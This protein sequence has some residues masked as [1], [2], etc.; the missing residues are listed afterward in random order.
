MKKNSKYKKFIKISLIVATLVGIGVLTKA[1]KPNTFQT[2][3][4]SKEP[5]IYANTCDEQIGTVIQQAIDSAK[6]SIFLR[7]YRVSAPNIISSLA[8]QIKDGRQVTIHYQTFKDIDSLKGPSVLLVQHP[9]KE[10]KLM[11]QKALAIDNQYAWLGTAN[12]TEASF[13]QDSNVIIGCKS[14]HLCKCIVQDTSGS[15][16]INGQ[17][18][19]YYT[20]PKDKALVLKTV[21]NCIQSAKKTIQ[22]AMFAL[23][24]SPII[25][26]LQQAQQRGVK[27]EVIIDKEFKNLCLKHLRSINSTFPVYCK[28]TP[29]KLH[30]KMCIID[31]ET[32]LIG[33]VN[34]SQNG[35]CLNSESL[36][37]LE[38]LTPK[39]KNKL[40]Q[41]WTSILVQSEQIHLEP[42]TPS[43]SELK[44]AA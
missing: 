1:P 9:E 16:T 10:H 37:L 2:F 24:Y 42:Q 13:L 20:L 19:S 5:V 23:S 21:I 8:N 27:V 12:Y 34:W 30:S 22:V 32:L 17:R 18:A 38:N 41:I 35:F 11:H 31:Q 33:S 7:I 28:T 26:E 14:E 4:E 6:Q 15:F 3:V 39:Q 36:L 40:K 25:Q 29:Y 44:D 43:V